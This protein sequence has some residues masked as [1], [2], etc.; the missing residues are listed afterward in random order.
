MIFFYFYIKLEIGSWAYFWKPLPGE[1]H[2][3]FN[4]TII[5]PGHS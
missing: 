5:D 3:Y 4:S 2:V 1:K